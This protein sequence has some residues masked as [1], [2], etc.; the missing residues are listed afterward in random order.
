MNPYHQAWKRLTAAARGVPAD[1]RDLSAP[2]GFATRV[3]ALA[4]AR[5]AE[6]P[7]AVF[8]ERISLRALIV[9]ALIAIASVAANITPIMNAIEEDVFALQDPVIEMLALG[10]PSQ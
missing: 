2:H 10:L 5:T 6:R 9:A 4:F 8:F 7:L 3:V 1:P